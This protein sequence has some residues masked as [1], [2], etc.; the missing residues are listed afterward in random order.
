MEE[1]GG[2]RECELQGCGGLQLASSETPPGTTQGEPTAALPAQCL[3][4]R[5]A[6][7]PTLPPA[8]QGCLRLSI[9]AKLDLILVSEDVT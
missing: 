7:L 6:E 3:T 8:P 2:G 5:W 9:L 4:H 1:N